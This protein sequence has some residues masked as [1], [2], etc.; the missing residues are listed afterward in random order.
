MNSLSAFSYCF[1]IEDCCVTGSQ[2]R[3]P[4]L[5]M[6][7]IIFTDISSLT[8]GLSLYYDTIFWLS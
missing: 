8:S 1:V 2:L 7:L 4:M 3:W 5:R 6:D